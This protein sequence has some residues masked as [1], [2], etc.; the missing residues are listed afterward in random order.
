M[1]EKNLGFYLE[2]FTSLKQ[3]SA[4]VKKNGFA[5][6]HMPILVLS[7]IQGFERGIFTDERIY[8]TPE[9]IDLFTSNWALLI[10]SGNYHPI[11]AQPFYHL[12]SKGNFPI[13]WRLVAK[14][15]CEIWLMNAGS[16]HSLSNLTSAVDHAEIDIELAILLTERQN[17]QLLQ[18]TVL[19]KYFPSQATIDLSS[20]GN[21]IDE[22]GQQIISEDPETYI[23]T[24]RHLKDKFSGTAPNIQRELYQQELLVRGGAFKRE[25]PKHYGYTCCISGLKIDAT[26]NISMIDAC[27]IVPFAKSY[28]D[29]ITNGIALCPNLHRAFDRGLIAVDDNYKVILSQHFIEP[30]NALYSIKKL[31]GISIILPSDQ[32]HYP[33]IENFAWHRKHI[34]KL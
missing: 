18:H 25:V 8:L 15:G 30:P 1:P 17:R 23:A 24:V 31:A 12:K 28:N 11:I 32:R 13:W 14:P 2:A 6:P 22:I 20:A 9:L 10:K 3:D 21:H 34:F 4:G 33:L 26:F 27:H 5:A 7:L 16:M 19:Q 29:T